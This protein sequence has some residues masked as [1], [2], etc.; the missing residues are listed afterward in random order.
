[1]WLNLRYI[2]SVRDILP[3]VN[4]VMYAH[5]V[6]FCSLMIKPVVHSLLCFSILLSRLNAFL[7][8]LKDMKMTHSLVIE[9]DGSH[10]LARTCLH[11]LMGCYICTAWIS[12]TL[13]RKCDVKFY[14]YLFIYFIMYLFIYLFLHYLTMLS[15]IDMVQ[16]Q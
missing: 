8:Q 12:W 10:C 5:L 6:E 2:L 16:C 4:E 14:F 7:R 15:N 13:V 9:A 11:F 1:M 3:S